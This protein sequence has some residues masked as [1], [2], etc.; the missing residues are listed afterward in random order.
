ML[1]SLR[2][3]VFFN[4]CSVSGETTVPISIPVIDL[5]GLD[6]DDVRRKKIVEK[7]G[8]ASESSGFFQII[9]H[10]IPESVLKEMKE[11]VRRFF[12]QETELSSLGLDS[13]AMTLNSQYR[14]DP[15][16]AFSDVAELQ[17]YVRLKQQYDGPPAY[18]AILSQCRALGE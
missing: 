9:N 3:H 16:V 12:D 18:Q 13:V 2:F 4:I 17:G 8:K 14:R 15:L 10:G 11:G 6:K 5:E 7:I 1:A